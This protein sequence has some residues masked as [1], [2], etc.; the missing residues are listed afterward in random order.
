MQ[1]RT[2]FSVT[3]YEVT[4]KQSEMDKKHPDLEYVV[5]IH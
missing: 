2:H 3:N 1:G 5:L 4:K